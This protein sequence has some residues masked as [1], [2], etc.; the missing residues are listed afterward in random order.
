[1]MAMPQDHRPLSATMLTIPW[2][3]RL[4]WA[5]IL[6]TAIGLLLWRFRTASLGQAEWVQWNLAYGAMSLCWVLW[7]YAMARVL[8]ES[9]AALTQIRFELAGV[10]LWGVALL[11]FWSRHE[12][13]LFKVNFDEPQHAAVALSM[14]LD[15][16]FALP[17][18]TAGW[19]ENLQILKY[20]S[21]SR[22]G[23][24]SY[25]VSLLHDF[26]GYSASN[27]FLLNKA[28]FLLFLLTI[29]TM[30]KK[31]CVSRTIAITSVLL[32]SSIPLF[33]QTTLSGSYDI[34]NLAFLAIYT[35]AILLYAEKDSPSRFMFAACTGVILALVRSESLVYLGILGAILLFRISKNR[36]LPPA[37]YA[38]LLTPGL[39]AALSVQVILTSDPVNISQHDERATS[40]L[41]SLDFFLGHSRAALDYFFSPDA[42]GT[43]CVW[44]A[45]AGLS[46]S[47]LL[48]AGALT[49][50]IRWDSVEKTWFAISTLA[51]LFYAG[52]LCSFWGGPDVAVMTRFTLPLWF[53][54]ILAPA[55]L[56]RH[57]KPS[58]RSLSTLP[59]MAILFFCAWTV[60][61]VVH[62][63]STRAM[64]KSRILA[65]MIDTCRVKND[66][67]TTFIAE[68]HLPFQANR[69]PAYSFNYFCNN[70]SR[71]EMAHRIGLHG[72]FVLLVPHHRYGVG[73]QL[74]LGKDVTVHD[75][76]QAVAQ[77]SAT[78]RG[79]IVAETTTGK[80]AEG[81]M[82]LL[83]EHPVAGHPQEFIRGYEILG[84]ALKT[85]AYRFDGAAPIAAPKFKTRQEYD[86][87]VR[88]ISP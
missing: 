47:L 6:T 71:F 62:A 36:R 18:A 25:L 55:L 84:V 86:A 66:G 42:D 37:S 88:Q 65:A 22:G 8:R 59:W 1:M 29:Y 13:V 7:L 32:A 10:L 73:E 33:A 85:G 52:T 44:V 43:G 28:A 69:I 70:A 53:V 58:T 63:K 23:F 67:R 4:N 40:G 19:D 83:F 21:S 3:N 27:P 56:L 61:A 75:Q 76:N 39:L 77:S 17:Y 5:F 82:R 45:W 15:G 79:D 14:H 78:P 30:I 87:F 26:T 2:L 81:G 9:I 46:A 31:V 80:D 74:G 12:P 34:T 68:S 60:P 54:L 38:L 72:R 20:T 41:F 49:R 35:L 51:V 16:R 48:I 57:L 50:R 64:N 11:F 24:Y